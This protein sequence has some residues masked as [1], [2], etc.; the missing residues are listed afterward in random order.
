MRIP[1]FFA[2]D[3]GPGSTLRPRAD[4][5]AADRWDLSKL[6]ADDVAWEKDLEGYRRMSER[7]PSFKGTLGKDAESLAAALCFLRDFGKVEER[8]AAYANLREAE[9]QGLSTARD[10]SARFMMT[11]AEAQAAWSYFDP[12]IQA[13]P[14]VHM[15]GFLAHPALA[16]FSTWLRKVLR[17]RPHVLSEKEERLL[18]MQIESNQTA[19]NAFSVLTDV[20]FDFG[21]L[22]RKS[23]V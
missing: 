1:S 13:I 6:Y 2:P 20:D 3:P 12:E 18:A 7:I 14:A 19:A 16:E 17:F 5:P 9:D 10:R 11:Q 23:V 15:A 4:V 21:S 8:L 22:D